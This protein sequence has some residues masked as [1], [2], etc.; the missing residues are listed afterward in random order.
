MPLRDCK[1]ISKAESDLN[2]TEA[3]VFDGLGDVAMLNN[4]FANMRIRSYQYQILSPQ[5]GLS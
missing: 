4:E 3:E 5:T 2:S 1:W